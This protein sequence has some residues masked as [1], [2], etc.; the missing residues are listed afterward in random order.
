MDPTHVARAR[1][2]IAKQSLP[3]FSAY[4][5]GLIFDTAITGVYPF[6]TVSQTV[7]RKW[8]N[9]GNR[10]SS[11]NVVAAI[12]PNHSFDL[13]FP[14]FHCLKRCLIFRQIWRIRPIPSRFKAL[15]MVSPQTY[16]PYRWISREGL[17]V[18]AGHAA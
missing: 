18:E 10:V 8:H 2:S 1:P 13:K 17:P 15:S 7:H 11:D 4:R 9:R 14:L 12:D 3:A 5:S 6:G 16:P